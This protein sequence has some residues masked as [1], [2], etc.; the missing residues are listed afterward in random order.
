MLG[1]NKIK[2]VKKALKNNK[3]YL[4]IGTVHKGDYIQKSQILYIEACECYSWIHIRGGSKFL[5]CKPIGYYQELLSVDNFLRI[6][7]SY[8]INPS[9]VK[10]Y[11]P[12][13]RLIHLK[14][15]CTLP[16]SYRK[17]RMISKK[18]NT[19][20]SNMSFKIAV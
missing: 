10:Y 17:N 4:L 16:V 15:E 14:G 19:I 11:E 18:V 3:N 12:R 2:N 8:L 5:G 20:T 1:V 13:Y 9:H 6:H 7:R